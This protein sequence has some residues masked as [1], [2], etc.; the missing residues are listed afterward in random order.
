M[1]TFCPPEGWRGSALPPD[2]YDPADFDVTVHFLGNSADHVFAYQSAVRW[3]GVVMLHDVAI[4][5]SLWE[6]SRQDALGELEAQVGKKSAARLTRRWELG[7]S[8]SEVFLLPSVTVPLR[9]AEHV[10]VHSR[11]AQLVIDAEAPGVPSTC[12]P[13]F[14]R[15]MPG[16]LY[17]IAELRR[18]LGLGPTSFVVGLFGYLAMHKRIPEAIEAVGQARRLLTARGVELA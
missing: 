5:S 16:E 17:D 10:I 15:R 8:R 3:G 7:A 11:Y 12:I 18:R 13:I 4:W 1:T 6:F 9:R 2:A 14:T